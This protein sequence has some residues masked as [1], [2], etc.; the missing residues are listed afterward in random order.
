LTP[1]VYGVAALRWR[2]AAIASTYRQ[3]HVA[4]MLWMRPPQQSGGAKV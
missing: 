3:A 4:G 2:R 1:A